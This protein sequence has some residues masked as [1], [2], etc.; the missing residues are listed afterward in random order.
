M[1]VYCKKTLLPYNT[2]ASVRVTLGT[3]SLDR[4]STLCQDRIVAVLAGPDSKVAVRAEIMNIAIDMAERITA[5][6]KVFERIS[7]EELKTVDA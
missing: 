7:I 6:I 5:A 4:F 3:C 1:I 2:Y